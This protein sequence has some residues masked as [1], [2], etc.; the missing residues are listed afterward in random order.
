MTYSFEPDDL[1]DI[2]SAADRL[3][4]KHG[5]RE[6]ADWARHYARNNYDPGEYGYA[7]WSA[8]ADRVQGGSSLV[9]NPK[10]KVRR[11]R[12]SRRRSGSLRENP[13]GVPLELKVGDVVIVERHPIYAR[14]EGGSYKQSKKVVADVKVSTDS[15]GDAVALVSFKGMKSPYGPFLQSFR[16]SGNVENGFWLR[17]QKS[18]Y[19]ILEVWRDDEEIDIE[20]G[21]LQPNPRAR[22]I[23]DKPSMDTR[24]FGE[25]LDDD[26]ID[27][28]SGAR[29]KHL[30]AA[31]RR[32]KTFHDKQPLRVAELAHDIPEKWVCVGDALAVMYRTDKWKP[33]GTDEDY[34]HLHD[35]DDGVPYEVAKGVRLYE[36]AT[37]VKKSKVHGRRPEELDHSASQRLPVAMPRAITLL[38]YCLGFFVRRDD[39][40]EI[41][42][43][44]PRGSYLFSSPKGDV[45]F[46][47][48]PHD[49]ANGAN[50]FLAA[51]AGGRLRVL[52]GGIDG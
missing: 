38:G 46:V 10:K 37:L 15:H 34:K 41:Y 24:F 19:Q 33:Y 49:Q 39:D 30:D 8:V 16:L 13:R 44:N 20:G 3:V 9:S 23:G 12:T 1:R 32:Y 6:A 17:G 31:M 14:R 2:H 21:A 45:L 27:A 52:K 11:R 51:L 40:G 22:A 4:D 47:Y 25:D 26:A 48:S 36:P 35:K 42:E 5:Q 50:G 18:R 29:G 7:F 28:V 43:V